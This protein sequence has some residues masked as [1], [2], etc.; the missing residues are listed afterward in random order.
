MRIRHLSPLT[1][2]KCSCLCISMLLSLGSQL[3]WGAADV[4]SEGA[5]LH[6]EKCATCHQNKVA[7]GDGNALYLRSDRKVKSLRQLASQIGLCNT[8]LRLDLFPEDEL[9]LVKYLNQQFYHFSQP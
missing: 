8:E 9:E 5:V 6:Q 7:T 2:A 3:A 1:F 4:N